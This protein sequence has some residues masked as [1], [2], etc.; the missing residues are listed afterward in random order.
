MST[1]PREILQ[2]STLIRDNCYGFIN[3]NPCYIIIVAASKRKFMKGN[4]W[5]VNNNISIMKH[6]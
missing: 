6:G 1:L 3:N 4:N 2:D 5:D